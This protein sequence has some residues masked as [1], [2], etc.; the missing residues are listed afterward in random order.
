MPEGVIV[1]GWSYVIGAY[2][3]V[4][5]GLALYVA[6]LFQRLRGS[7]RRLDSA[8]HAA[9]VAIWAAS[10]DGQALFISV[11]IESD[12]PVP[13][14]GHHGFAEVGRAPEQSGIPHV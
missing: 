12:Q 10:A 9:R 8:E 4:A 1:G 5:V 14:V 13:N 6:S 11:P 7:S 3:V 2:A